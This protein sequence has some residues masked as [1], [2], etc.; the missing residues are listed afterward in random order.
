MP[1]SMTALSFQFSFAGTV[2]DGH[3]VTAPA[4]IVGAGGGGSATNSGST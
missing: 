1:T 4:G 2:L 3:T